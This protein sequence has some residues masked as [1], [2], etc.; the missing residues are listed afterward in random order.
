M[1]P[2]ASHSMAL[3]TVFWAMA[4]DDNFHVPEYGLSQQL[5]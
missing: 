1:S 4:N 5:L 2:A 3:L